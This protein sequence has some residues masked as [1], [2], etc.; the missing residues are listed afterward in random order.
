MSGIGARFIADGYSVPKPLILVDGIPMIEHVINLYP[1]VKDIIFICNKGHIRNT[2]M[3]EELHRICPFGRVLLVEESLKK[4]PVGAI[5][6][7]LDSISDDKEIIVSYCDFGAE[8]DFN[9]F[10][11]HA[12]SENL[13]GV[14]AAY[15]GF[16][17]HMLGE[18]HYAY[19]TLDEND[20]YVKSIQE[21]IPTKENKLAEIASS[22][23]YYFKSGKIL[24]KYFKMLS[25]FGPAINKEWYVSLVYKYLILDKL[26]VGVFFIKKMLQWGT[27]Y[28]L[29]T[30]LN[31]SQYFKECANFKNSSKL[32]GAT[33]VLPMAGNGLRFIKEGYAVPKPILPI[34]GEP[35]FVQAIKCL[36]ICQNALIICLDSLLGQ[37]DF[38][39]YLKDFSSRFHIVSIPAIT[40]GQA[41]TCDIGIKQSLLG[42]NDAILI[43]ACDNGVLYDSAVFDQLL[44]DENPD[45]IVWSFR[46]NPASKNNPN[47]YSWLDVDLN[48]NVLSV[49]TKKFTGKNPLDCHAIIGTMYFKKISYFQDGF[50]K[51][52]KNNCLTNNEFYVD[53]IISRCIENGL[54]V[55]IFEVKNYIC[56]GTPGDYEAYLYWQDYFH[57]NV[58]HPYIKPN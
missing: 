11:E 43:T 34:N 36:P 10:I 41:R 23:T 45:V 44:E 22:G 48:N 53:D 1:G 12:R 27:P 47:M 35:M 3:A 16:H 51:N 49:S 28:D 46:N 31:W 40:D 20:H 56:W 13:D 9:G 52:V 18:D 30:Y 58:N 29:E 55:K 26:R 15:T 5:L 6:E 50:D 7:C 21:K 25:V 37:V 19:M 2:N 32:D 57:N 17:P 14:I 4:G 39:G 24:K 33:L 38:N 8:W 42:K 54:N